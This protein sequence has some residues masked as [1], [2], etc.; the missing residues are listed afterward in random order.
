LAH[1]SE[2]T[3]G[4]AKGEYYAHVEQSVGRKLDTKGY[5]RMRRSIWIYRMVIF[6][7]LVAAR[8]FRREAERFNQRIVFL[9]KCCV[10]LT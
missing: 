2:D 5:L 8:I 6:N 7:T 9:D 1:V 10:A 3:L 4:E